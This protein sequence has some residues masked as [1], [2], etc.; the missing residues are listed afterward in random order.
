MFRDEVP[1]RKYRC[2]VETGERNTAHNIQQTAHS[3]EHRQ[4]HR[5]C[6]NLQYST[7]QS[8]NK[9]VFHE[10]YSTAESGDSTMDANKGSA[11]QSIWDASA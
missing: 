6:D 3:R 7:V 8:R 10:L 1:V 9:E 5:V 2:D 11:Q 4:T